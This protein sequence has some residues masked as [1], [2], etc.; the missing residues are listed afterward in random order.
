MLTLDAGCCRRVPV[1]SR[2]MSKHRKE[3]GAGRSQVGDAGAEAAPQRPDERGGDA[4]RNRL[5]TIEWADD[6]TQALDPH[7]GGLDEDPIGEL[8]D[9]GE[10]NA[11]YREDARH[12]TPTLGPEDDRDR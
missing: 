12:V 10:S 4:R 7:R 6:R 1:E 2:A 5:D 11:H 8:L 9:G 3:D